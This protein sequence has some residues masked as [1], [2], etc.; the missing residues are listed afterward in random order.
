MTLSILRGILHNLVLADSSVLPS[1]YEKILN[2]GQDKL[3]SVETARSLLELFFES[4]TRNYVIVDGLDSCGKSEMKQVCQF[5]GG[6]V[7]RC[8]SYD[9]GRLRLL[10]T[11]QY[12]PELQKPLGSAETIA[13]GANDN[14]RDIE[15][16]LSNR[17]ESVANKLGLDKENIQLIFNRISSPSES[18]HYSYELPQDPTS[19]Y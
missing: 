10:I 17:V 8:D 7:D 18:I 4:N 12:T 6:I 19:P 9:P 3:S 2:S 5:L 1:C 14:T 11:S 15:C 16:Y 13:I